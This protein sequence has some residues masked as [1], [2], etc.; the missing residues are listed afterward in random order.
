M[1]D[2]YL[3]LHSLLNYC[4]WKYILLKLMFQRMCTGPTVPGIVLNEMYL[5]LPWLVHTPPSQLSLPGR[6]ANSCSVSPGVSHA[7][8]ITSQFHSPRRQIIGGQNQNFKWLF[9]ITLGVQGLPTNNGCCGIELCARL[10]LMGEPRTCRTPEIDVTPRVWNWR[11][12]RIGKYIT[13]RTSQV[14]FWRSPYLR[15][16]IAHHFTSQGNRKLLS[17]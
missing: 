2:I 9:F 12:H 3:D 4:I 5:A 13:P 15:H 7:R 6:Q 16:H 10:V 1:T 14:C 8:H 11:Y 17:R